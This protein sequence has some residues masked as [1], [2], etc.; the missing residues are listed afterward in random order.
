MDK[1]KKKL[2]AM[3]VMF[4][5]LFILGGLLIT[6]IMK[7]QKNTSIQTC[8]VQEISSTQIMHV[9]IIDEVEDYDLNVKEQPTPSITPA[10][11]SS[12]STPRAEN[13][14]IAEI[15][16]QTDRKT[17]TY[18]VMPNVDEDTLKK[19]IGH[20]PSSAWFGEEGLC[21]LMGHRDTD[22][23]ILQYVET[24]EIILVKT[25]EKEYRYCVESITIADND[26]ELSFQSMA[27]TYLILITCYPFRYSGHAPQKYIVYSTLLN[28]S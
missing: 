10:Q 25:D 23:Y 6:K 8:T 12:T 2:F 15:T 13:V 5:A 22:F 1:R 3:T 19:N 14:P 16:I 26:D 9:E 11:L 28:D 17:R 7:E 27:G 4:I 20:L 21:V 24:G 18:D